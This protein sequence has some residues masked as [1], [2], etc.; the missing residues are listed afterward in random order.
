MPVRAGH[1]AADGSAFDHALRGLQ[2]RRHGLLDLH[3]LFCLRPQLHCLEPKIGKR[4]DVYN[5]DP[6]VTAEVLPA[7]KGGAPVLISEFPPTRGI[8]SAARDQLVTN[9]PLGLSVLMRDRPRAYADPHGYPWQKSFQLTARIRNHFT[10][11][12]RFPSFLEGR[13]LPGA[14]RGIVPR[15]PETTS[16]VISFPRTG[17]RRDDEDKRANLESSKAYDRRA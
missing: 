5:I 3:V 10:S 16:F 1:P 15:A 11:A 2:I 13:L 7:F 14:D 9:V 4:A 6:R 17:S 12:K 8:E